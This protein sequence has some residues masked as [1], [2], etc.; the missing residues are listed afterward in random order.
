MDT[1]M[2]ID[3]RIAI[4]GIARMAD[5]LGNSFLIVVLPLYVTSGLIE[6]NAIGL[7]ESLVTG[8][9]L[10]LFGIINSMTQPF[11][12]RFSDR[13][14]K[15]KLFVVAGLIVLAAANFSFSLVGNY[16]GLLAI[17]ALQ[18][19]GAALT[20]TATIALVNELSEIGNRGGNMGTFN[21]FRLVGFGSGPLAAGVVLENGPYVLANVE[22]SG[23]NASF[24]LAALAAMVSV[25]LVTFF[26]H[27]PEETEPTHEEL[28]LAVFA[29][30]GKHVFD[31]IFT[32]GLASL[33]M[34]ASIALLAP[35]E[36]QINA[37]LNQGPTLF[38]IQFASFIGALAVT[39]PIIGSLS[40]SYGRRKFIIVGLVFLVPTTL[41]QG[42]VVTSLQLIIARLLQGVSG[43]MVFAPA[44]ALAG[45]F[46]RR[47]QSGAQ[48]SVLTVAFGLG[49]SFGQIA[50][51]YLIRY[52]Y[53]APF[54]FGAGIAAVGAILVF[55]QVPERAQPTEE[56]HSGV[57]AGVESFVD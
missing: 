12:G 10:A 34:A 36:P 37:H 26:V 3:K 47:G 9:V 56:R 14:G 46:A 50:S 22:I 31:P 15:R 11:A 55:T 32:L 57:A 21:S 52:G 30:D 7:S 27:D 6:G 8:I 42:F 49:I 33:T 48:L 1:P 41:A 39:Q 44:L 51:G 28:A 38:G 4:L 54:V 18:G 2:N 19:V 20:I 53:V 24:Y 25:L 13:A 17:R 40:D 16:I 45:D 23:F 5:A 35:I 43:A 29:R